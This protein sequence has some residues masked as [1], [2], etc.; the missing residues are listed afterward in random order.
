MPQMLAS[1][2]QG[3]HMSIDE[4]DQLF[5]LAGHN[6]PP[7]GTF[8]EHINPGL[9]RHDAVRRACPAVRGTG[10]SPTPPPGRSTRPRSMR[11]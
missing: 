11:S 8:N 9:L 6:P 7:R 10:G 1:I 4:R 5:R 3:L 2:A